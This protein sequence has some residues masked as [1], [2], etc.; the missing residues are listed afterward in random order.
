MFLILLSISIIGMLLK[1]ESKKSPLS[2]DSELT[3]SKRNV[4]LLLSS[5]F[6]MAFIYGIIY[7]FFPPYATSIGLTAFEIGLIISC[8]GIAN[9]ISHFVC[10]YI[11]ERFDP[12][13]II[14]GAVP[15]F[16]L[17]PILIIV[18]NSLLHFLVVFSIIG[19]LAGTLFSI[20]IIVLVG[21]AN[22]HE[23]GKFA[24]IFESVLG[25]GF[26]IGPSFTGLLVSNYNIS[27]FSI[28][29]IAIIPILSAQI[30]WKFYKPRLIPS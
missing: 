3:I 28:S 23:R 14:L 27:P 22:K 10:I 18:A 6:T 2:D 15:M 26:L 24:G 21:G 29:I 12:E 1:R 13:K 8:M 7:T 11:I 20:C 25:V 5:G 4:K 17:V 9:T 16:G 19:M 30:Y